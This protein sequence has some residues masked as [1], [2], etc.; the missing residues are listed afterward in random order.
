MEAL[1]W[2]LSPLKDIGEEGIT[3]KSKGVYVTRGR[4]HSILG[5]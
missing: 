5:I 2:E 1:S 3:V 4:N